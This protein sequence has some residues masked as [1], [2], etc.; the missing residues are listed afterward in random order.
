MN[1]TAVEVHAPVNERWTPGAHSMSG[2]LA[3]IKMGVE[4]ELLAVTTTTGLFVD[5]AT[6]WLICAPMSAPDHW[7]AYKTF[8]MFGALTCPVNVEVGA[9][10]SPVDEL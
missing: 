4:Y 1:V 3:V 5:D 8:S 6:A 2:L 7:S 9:V 10:K